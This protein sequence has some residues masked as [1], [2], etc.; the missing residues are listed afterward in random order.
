MD[1]ES[2]FEADGVVVADLRS[3]LSV[4]EEEPARAF[5]NKKYQQF[6]DGLVVSVK[7]ACND[8]DLRQQWL[9]D[10]YQKTLQKYVANVKH[11]YV[12][13][14]NIQAAMVEQQGYTKATQYAV[15]RRVLHFVC[16]FISD[17]ICS[18]KHLFGAP[19]LCLL[20]HPLAFVS[21]ISVHSGCVLHL[22]SDTHW[23]HPLL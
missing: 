7:R 3:H 2:A 15:Q 4:A 20:S 13:H 5:V 11:P 6:S 9:E 17:R 16:F 12:P 1:A 10:C 19:E 22:T 18:K 14:L 23:L 8:S 21:K